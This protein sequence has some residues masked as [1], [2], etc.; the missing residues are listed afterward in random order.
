M[1]NTKIAKNNKDKRSR[2][3]RGE[4]RKTDSR[5]LTAV[6]RVSV[7]AGQG[8]LVAGAEQ[9]GPVDRVVEAELAVVGDVDVTG[10]YLAQGLELQRR[11][12][13]LFQDQQRDAATV[14]QRHMG[15][16][17][18]KEITL[19]TRYGGR[20]EIVCRFRHTRLWRDRACADTKKQNGYQMQKYVPFSI[21]SGIQ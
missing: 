17:K 4:E 15:F 6:F 1:D 14:G 16:R 21:S 5:G 19:Q 10:A 20:N 9:A 11:D 13:A 8:F 18:Q 2:W 7:A 3:I 12:P